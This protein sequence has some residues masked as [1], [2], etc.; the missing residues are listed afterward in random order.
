MYYR[1]VDANIIRHAEPDS[2]SRGLSN[3]A[4]V[5]KLRDP[6]FVA[7]D[8]LPCKISLC[9]KT[10]G[11]ASSGRRKKVAFTLAEVLITLGVIGVVAA[12]TIPN[13]VANYQ[14]K[15]AVTQYKKAFSE[16]SQVLKMAE[17]DNGSIEFWNFTSST[18]KTKDFADNYLYPYLKIQK[19]CDFLETGCWKTPV[20]LS[21]TSTGVGLDAIHLSAIT[22]SGYSILFWV[23][24]TGK[25]SFIY[26]D[27]DG[28]DKGR[29]KLGIDVFIFTIYF[30]SSGYKAEFS[31]YGI[32]PVK[33]SKDEII[34]ASPGGCRNFV[35]ATAGAYCS[36]LIILD[37]WEISDDYP[38]E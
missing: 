32:S 37:G 8:A 12:L 25:S 31:P 1:Q 24:A 3:K 22:I 29:N 17:V 33:R 26:V 20:S 14:K 9:S 23:S 10:R 36:S 5:V 11:A 34:S 6:V 30:A 38:W 27:I 28:P 19:K 21:N 35:G 4:K 16:I 13:L 7:S 15:Q 18:N 2:A